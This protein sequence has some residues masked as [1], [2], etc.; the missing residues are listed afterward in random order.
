MGFLLSKWRAFRLGEVSALVLSV[1]PTA[2]DSAPTN[3]MLESAQASAQ[4][5]A[6]DVFLHVAPAQTSGETC[7]REQPWKESS[8][9]P[10]LW[11]NQDS[12]QDWGINE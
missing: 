9:D 1:D 7:R 11:A 5:A 4:R 8:D 12:H 6:V 10:S 2:N 3:R